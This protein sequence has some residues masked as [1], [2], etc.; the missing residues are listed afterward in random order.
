[1]T[2]FRGRSSFVMRARMIWST[3]GRCQ[4]EFSR[5]LGE[6]ESWADAPSSSDVS[7]GTMTGRKTEG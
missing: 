5:P 7:G 2:R 6:R 4:L 3:S 1:M